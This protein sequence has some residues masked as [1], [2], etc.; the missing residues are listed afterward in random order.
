MAEKMLN[1]LI[2]TIEGSSV[3]DGH[4]RLG[5]F[6]DELEAVKEALRQTE[7]SMYNNRRPEVYYR[8]IDTSHSSPLRMVLEGVPSE[9]APQAKSR[10]KAV[11]KTFT[12]S[13]GQ[14]HRNRRP[15]NLDVHALQAYKDLGV[16]L[17]RHVQRIS[18]ADE[19]GTVI[20]ID[21]AFQE[22][23]AEVIGPDQ[24]SMGSVSGKL[25]KL[26]VHNTSRFEIFPTV[27]P[28]RVVCNFDPS[29]LQNVLRAVTRY[30]TV[31]GVV[32]YKQWSPFPHAVDMNQLDT[33]ELAEDLPSLESIRGLA[34]DATGDLSSEDFV[35]RMR[36]E[37]W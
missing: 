18:I 12:G 3:D 11:V 6:L 15:A 30:V 4:V 27:G 17:G 10:A 7:R 32:R 35:R 13:V 16:T 28:R 34:P 37:E 1:R 9:P 5:D 25:E 33:H 31:T 8:I 29:D 20:P 2:I 14:L 23:V 21:R 22:K 24:T 26:N 36:D 19:R